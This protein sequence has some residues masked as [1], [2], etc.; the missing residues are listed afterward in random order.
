MASDVKTINRALQPSLRLTLYLSAQ[1]SVS[2]VTPQCG[3]LAESVAL[4]P[5]E[6]QQTS[7]STR[8]PSHL[9]GLGESVARGLQSERQDLLTMTALMQAIRVVTTW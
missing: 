5:A 6:Y 1:C 3:R 8:F 4:S 7:R 2:V 9:R